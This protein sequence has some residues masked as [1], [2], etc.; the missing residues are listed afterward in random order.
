LSEAEFIEQV[1][2]ERAR[3][4]SGEG[5]VFALYAV[6]NGIEDVPK[7]EHRELTDSERALLRQLRLKSYALFQAEHPD[8]RLNELTENA[9][10]CRNP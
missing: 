6:M 3:N 4:L 10:R 7:D 8:G 9:E 1:E 2:A 5:P